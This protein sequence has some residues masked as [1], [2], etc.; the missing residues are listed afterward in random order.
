M[1]TL[2][3]ETRLRSGAD[4]SYTLRQP[5]FNIRIATKHS[6]AYFLGPYSRRLRSLPHSVFSVSNL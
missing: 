4:G 6:F 5:C 1:A 2:R 3:A